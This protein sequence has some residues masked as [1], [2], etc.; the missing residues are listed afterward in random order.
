MLIFKSYIMKTILIATDFSEKSKN[1]TYFALELAKETK[2]K[3]L[4][5][6]GYEIPVLAGDPEIK[7]GIN[8]DYDVKSRELIN[9]YVE[10]IKNE[11]DYK[12]DIQGVSQLGFS[13]DIIENI[14]KTSN[15][16]LVVI[17]TKGTSNII[18]TIIGSNAYQ[19]ILKLSCPVLTV[20][21]F[22]LYKGIKRVLYATEFQF[23]DFISLEST[24]DLFRSFEPE[25]IVANV[26]TDRKNLEIHRERMD[27]FMEIATERLKYSKLSYKIIENELILEG[28][29]SEIYSNQVDIV[30]MSTVDRSLF[31]TLF[32]SSIVKRMTY[33]AEIPL[34]AHHISEDNPI[35]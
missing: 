25:I 1:A 34:L 27:W 24:L 4:I 32:H 5:Y 9:N 11:Y 28:I 33:H 19:M 13:S 7:M 26:C 20:P 10:Q 35:R 23:N 31:D 2:A 17:G 14:V 30:S 16:A 18:E 3:V 6:H 15:V 12:P 8:M 22:A 29:N 21:P